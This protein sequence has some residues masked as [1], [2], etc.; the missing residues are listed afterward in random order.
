[1]HLS[2]YCFKTATVLTHFF[3]TQHDTALGCFELLSQSCSMRLPWN[4][5]HGGFADWC[6]STLLMVAAHKTVLEWFALTLL[7][8]LESTGTVCPVGIY[9][10]A[11]CGSIQLCTVIEHTMMRTIV[12]SHAVMCTSCKAVQLYLCTSTVPAVEVSR[13][14]KGREEVHNMVGGMSGRGKFTTWTAGGFRPWEPTQ[15]FK[16]RLDWSEGTKSKNNNNNNKRI[17]CE[18]MQ[19]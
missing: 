14:C 3:E 2:H 13:Q 17:S 5:T 9:C 10:F 12:I 19:R 1:M 6:N 11:Y 18:R 16:F 4:W 15:Q 7:G 8:L